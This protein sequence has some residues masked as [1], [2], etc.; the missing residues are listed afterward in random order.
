MLWPNLNSLFVLCKKLDRVKDCLIVW[1]V[2]FLRVTQGEGRMG[3]G[4]RI[5]ISVDLNLT[6]VVAKFELARWLVEKL[7]SVKDILIV[8]IVKFFMATHRQG[9]GGGGKFVIILDRP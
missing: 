4:L 3:R 1:I 2:K 6:Y 5:Y 9:E 7:D 8:W